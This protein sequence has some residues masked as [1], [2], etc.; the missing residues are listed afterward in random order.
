MHVVGVY[1]F[2]LHFCFASSLSYQPKSP[3][4]FLPDSMPNNLENHNSLHALLISLS[5]GSYVIEINILTSITGTL[6]SFEYVLMKRVLPGRTSRIVGRNILG[7]S[8]SKH[9][10]YYSSKIPRAG[11]VVQQ[12]IPLHG[13]SNSMNNRCGFTKLNYISGKYISGLHDTIRSIN[14]SWR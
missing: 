12:P 7:F 9:K 1:L 6:S 11:R 8:G 10:T 5:I 4:Y 13:Y 2:R 3:Y 14:E